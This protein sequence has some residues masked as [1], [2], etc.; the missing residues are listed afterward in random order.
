MAMS[1]PTR[2]SR[3]D[4]LFDRVGASAAFVGLDVHKKTIHAAVWL[5]ER[6][7]GTWVMPADVTTVAALLTPYR[8]TIT[9]VVYEAGPTGYALARALRQ[10]GVRVEVVAPGRSP[11][12]AARQQK[13]DRLDAERL[14]EYAAKGLLVAV[15]VP[16]QTEEA[17]RQLVR[18]REQLV[19]KRRRVKQQIKSF[20]LQHG[21]AE[22]RGLSTW[23]RAA[24]AALRALSLGATLR[25]CL[26]VLLDGL[27]EL[28]AHVR[29][30]ER[31][32]RELAQSERHAAAVQIAR[33]HPG[34]GPIV[35]MSYLLEVHRGGRFNEPGEVASYIGLAPRVRQSGQSRRDGP[36]VR[37][38]RASVRA[39]LVE[40]AWRWRQLD[41]AARRRYRRLVANT[42]SAKK[43]IVALARRLAINLWAMLTRR[44]PYRA[45]A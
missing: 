8:H 31:A 34:V 38:G 45:C 16:T 19:R 7:V 33:T 11:R 5:D 35:A 18:L 24:L 27:D 1:K 15:A 4:K 37:T 36:I 30:I 13:A 21:V 12:L 41:A 2:M 14:A 39:L 20:L 44:E 17:D 10:A 22:P 40:A 23:S 6:I 9:Q 3:V 32:L 29:R 43:A 26:D 25:L 28:V 42:G